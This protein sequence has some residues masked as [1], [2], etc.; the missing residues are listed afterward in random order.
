MFVKMEGRQEEAEKAKFASLEALVAQRD[1]EVLELRE[2]LAVKDM[3][4]ESMRGDLL[5]GDA[6]HAL[7]TIQKQVTV[8][9][10]GLREFREKFGF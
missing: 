3:E 2:R 4:I 6:K 1:Q 7:S 9:A 5:Q 10:M 8:H